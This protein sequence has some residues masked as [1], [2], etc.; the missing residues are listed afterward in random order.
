M[1]SL[2][3][4]QFTY[5]INLLSPGNFE[6]YFLLSLPLRGFFIFFIV[7]TGNTWVETERPFILTVF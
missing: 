2:L 4:W 7:K 6:M 3:L 1:Q 5:R